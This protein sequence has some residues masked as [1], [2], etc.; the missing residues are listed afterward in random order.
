MVTVVGSGVDSI[1]VSLAR[2]GG[3]GRPNGQPPRDSGRPPGYNKPDGG[4]GRA[5]SPTIA[6]DHSQ[7]VNQSEAFEIAL[8][9]VALQL[10]NDAMADAEEAMAETEEDA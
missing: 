2:T 10:M 9:S 3:Q 8:R 5:D 4:S 6:G 1:G 7:S